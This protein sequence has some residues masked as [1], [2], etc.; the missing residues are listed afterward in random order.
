M[1]FCKLAPHKSRDIGPGSGAFVRP[2]GGG[3]FCHYLHISA[4]ALEIMGIAIGD[5]VD[6]YHDEKAREIGLRKSQDGHGNMVS[7]YG[8][9]GGGKLNSI[10]L[11]DVQLPNDKQRRELRYDPKSGLWV[12][13]IYLPGREAKKQQ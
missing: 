13:S 9:A 11:F 10:M 8:C 12:F 6:L 2:M 7:C 1:A 3:Y 4:D 5:V